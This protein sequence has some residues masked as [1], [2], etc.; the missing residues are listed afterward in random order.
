MRTNLAL[1]AL[2]AG[3]FGIGVTEFT[4]TGMLPL[5]AVGLHVS[6]PRAGLLVSGYAVGVLLGAPVMTL[7]FARTPRRMLLVGLMGLFTLGNG[8]AAMA[9][10]YE[11]LLVARLVTALN[12]GAFFGVGAVV[13]A[14]IVS[15]DRRAVA[16]AAMFSGLTV[17]AIGGAPLAAWLGG[18]LGWHAAFACIA[19]VG[20]VVMT[21]LR[22]AL[23]PLPAPS[24][25]DI[26]T[27]LR[28]LVRGPVL[29][30]LTLTVLGFSAMFTV[31]TYLVP[32][33]RV[34]TGTSA[35]FATATLSV[36]GLGLTI[37]NW[38]GGRGASRSVDG[39][40]MACLLGIAVVLMAFW[41]LAGSELAAVV[42]VFLLGAGSFALVPPLQMRVMA[43]ATGAPVLASA[44]NIGAFNLGNAVGAA[45]GG[46]VIDA[47][48][49]YRAVL[50]AGAG[51]ALSALLFVSALY[52]RR[53]KSLAAA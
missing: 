17:S 28:V 10:S 8:L 14:E 20:V 11:V 25:V 34:V 13:A 39:T 50:P 41:L 4:P 37:G 21:A 26:R 15:Q 2:A 43:E 23:P 46:A 18:M 53:I 36:F 45:L 5:I 51:M 30:G 31:F 6:I 22:V 35:V 44:M 40:I 27:E 16:V 24:S 48:W 3:A 49:G 33:L 42:L 29:A 9:S 1:L 32:L 7:I 19:A 52:R 47:G 12:H 38:L